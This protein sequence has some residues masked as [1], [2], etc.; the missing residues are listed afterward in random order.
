MLSRQYFYGL[1]FCFV[2]YGCA[3]Q[4]APTGGNKDTSPPKLEHAFPKNLQTHFAA[5]KIRF[6]FDEFVVL[7]NASEQIVI[8]PAL[9]QKPEIYA[10]KRWIVVDLKHNNLLPNTTYT[11]N[12]GNAIGD[13]HE[14]NVLADLTYVFST[15]AFIDSCFFS[16]VV[17]NAF[18]NEPEKNITV[19]VYPSSGFSD[20]VVYKNKPTYFSKTSASGSF[21]IN[22]LPA[23]NYRLFAFSDD[24]KNLLYDA[25]EKC[26]FD[27]IVHH[28]S[29][30]SFRSGL[31]F[32]L[33]KPNSYHINRIV[34]TFCTER[35]RF[36]FLVYKPSEFSVSP[37]YQKQYYRYT[38]PAPDD[39]DSI[40]VIVPSCPDSMFFKI[41]TPDTSYEVLL[42]NSRKKQKSRGFGISLSEVKKTADDLLISCTNPFVYVDTSRISIYKDSIRISYTLRYTDSTH[43]HASI[44]SDWKENARYR[45]LI[46]DSAVKD[47]WGVF[48]MLSKAQVPLWLIKIWGI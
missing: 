31:V 22:N 23:D 17:K 25:T 26:A 30:S 20:S 43:R 33:Y 47:V 45:F 39:M 1:L 28:S 29:D 36:V 9:S 34:D 44:H 11:I 46:K 3:H 40:I 42:N 5:K 6:V 48:L 2:F 38:K 41:S 35:D 10:D 16:G 8:S 32:F 37:V 21:K 19:G 13:F 24:N 15:G 4:V 27:T 12:F 14:N 7:N 18:T